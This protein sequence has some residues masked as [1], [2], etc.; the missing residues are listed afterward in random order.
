MTIDIW[1][2][3]YPRSGNSLVA[4]ELLRA[5]PGGSYGI[6]PKYE[7]YERRTGTP[8]DG[9]FNAIA[10]D[11]TLVAET[12]TY[13]LVKTHD[14]PATPHNVPV[15][16]ILRDGR[17][18]LVSQY[19]FTVPDKRHS[20]V[21]FWEDL[22]QA[23]YRWDQWHINWS[24]WLH[25][26]GALML[27]YEHLLAFGFCE[28][29]QAVLT[30]LLQS[31]FTRQTVLPIDSLRVVDAH[32]FRRGSPGEWQTLPLEEQVYLERELAPTLGAWGYGPQGYDCSKV[33]W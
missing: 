25:R 15:I 8:P 14:P 17:D 31:P 26:R 13:R 12:P 2:V 20:P 24:L 10:A 16:S 4:L 9:V 32:H 30:R 28:Y 11:P 21:Q 18:A 5:F 19:H 29:E 33:P 1:L 7:E 22:K 27:R 6:D 3:S 23:G